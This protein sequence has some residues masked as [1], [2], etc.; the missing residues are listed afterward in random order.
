MAMFGTIVMED[1]TLNF[2][3]NTE[4]AGEATWTVRELD[5]EETLTGPGP[6]FMAALGIALHWEGMPDAER[7]YPAAEA[8]MGKIRWIP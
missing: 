3:V 1:T 6:A 5:E 2:S 8:I 4:T 7:D